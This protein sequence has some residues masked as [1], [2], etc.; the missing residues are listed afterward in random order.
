MQ[1]KFSEKKQFCSDFD[2]V[3]LH[4]VY[5]ILRIFFLSK[6]NRDNFF[7]KKCWINIIFLS[8]LSS[9]KLPG[10]SGAMFLT[11]LPGAQILVPRHFCIES[12]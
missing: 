2:E 3:F 1:K 4:M 6:K 5:K 11:L 12:P 8:E 9:L 10:S 7:W